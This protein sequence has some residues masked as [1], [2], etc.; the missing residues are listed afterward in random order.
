[1]KKDALCQPDLPRIW[2][3]S[4]I[5]EDALMPGPLVPGPQPQWLVLVSLPRPPHVLTI[6]LYTPR[7]HSQLLLLQRY[8]NCFLKGT[9]DFF[10]KVTSVFTKVIHVH[11]VKS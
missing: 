3:P 2:N 1:M 10:Q 9:G 4:R 7:V 8:Q 11:G 6:H 5:Q